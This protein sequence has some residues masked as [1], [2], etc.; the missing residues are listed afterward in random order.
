MG[1]TSWRKVNPIKVAASLFAS[2]SG[3]RSAATH[4]PLKARKNQVPESIKN[5]RNL[6][7]RIWFL[8][9]GSWDL[10]LGIWFLG[11]GSWDLVLGIWLRTSMANQMSEFK[12][13]ANAHMRRDMEAG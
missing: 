8:G 2:P 10:V 4:W 5:S 12:A 13:I 11:F 7:L 6:I 3:V 9:F 1:A